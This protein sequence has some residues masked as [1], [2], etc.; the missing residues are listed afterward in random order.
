MSSQFWYLSIFIVDFSHKLYL[1]NAVLSFQFLYFFSH[2]KHSLI[3]FFHNGSPILFIILNIFYL[4][5][6]RLKYFLLFP[7][8][9]VY[10]INIMIQ[11]FYFS[12]KLFISIFLFLI[13]SLKLRYFFLKSRTLLRNSSLF[14]MTP[15]IY[16]VKFKNFTFHQTNIFMWFNIF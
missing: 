4:M 11:I 7:F 8:S 15:F 12:C 2:L 5:F 14:F 10:L 6:I 1:F 3:F 16:I 9:W 13:L